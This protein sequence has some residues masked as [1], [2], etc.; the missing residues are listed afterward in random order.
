[1]NQDRK[2][3]QLGEYAPH[4]GCLLLNVKRGSDD[5]SDEELS[6]SSVEDSFDE[7]NPRLSSW[8]NEAASKWKALSE[9]DRAV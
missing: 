9:T 8:M 6:S 2:L 5:E 1:M 4:S 3:S 7:E